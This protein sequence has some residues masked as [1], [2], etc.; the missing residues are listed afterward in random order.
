VNEQKY[1][2]STDGSYIDQDIHRLFPSFTVTKIDSASNSFQT[3][4]S[5]SAPVGMGYEY[6][7]P[8][9]AKKLPAL[10]PRYKKRYDMLEDIKFATK[11]AGRKDH[12]KICRPG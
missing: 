8:T 5:L 9:A 11:Q 6:L 10:P 12:R 2:A 7:N 1:F 4:R 3:R